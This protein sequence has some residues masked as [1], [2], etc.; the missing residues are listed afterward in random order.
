MTH[1]LMEALGR[2]PTDPG[3]NSDICVVFQFS[4][5]KIRKYIYLFNAINVQNLKI[6][7]SPIKIL[8]NT[9]FIKFW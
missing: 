3:S 2:T 9:I 1:T 7:P 4:L 5:L 8:Q 6:Q